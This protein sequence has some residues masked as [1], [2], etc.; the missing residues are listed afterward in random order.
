[1]KKFFLF[2]FILSFY[3]LST[4]S[5]YFPPNNSNQW[6]TLAPQRLG[7]CDYKIDSLYNF[8]ESSN[9]RGFIL[10]KDGKIV[11]EKY[12]NGHDLSKVWYWASAGKS[13][14]A[15]MV[16]IAQQD[17]LLNINDTS[18][19]Y[20]GKG[21]TS[22]PQAKEDLITIYHQLSMSSGL[23]D[24]VA[25]EYCTIDTCLQYLSDAGTRW[26]YHNGP[27][28]LLDSVLNI[29]TK[30]KLNQYISQKLSGI[31]GIQGVFIK[32]GFNNVFYSTGRNMA[33]FGLLNLNKGN[34]NGT[35]ILKDKTYFEKMTTSSQALN[36]SYGYLWWLNGKSSYK[37]PGLQI[38]FPGSLIPNAP[39]D[40]Y[41]AMGKN[42]QFICVI[43][44]QNMVWVRF[45][46]NPD[47]SLVPFL[48]NGEIWKYINDLTCNTSNSLNPTPSKIEIKNTRSSIIINAVD[49]IVSCEVYDISG[50]CVFVSRPNLLHFDIENENWSGLYLL[51]IVAENGYKKVFKII[52]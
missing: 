48:L 17:G 51:Q 16:G 26:A 31:T 36:P 15:F 43:P 52:K 4:Q 10:L 37:V 21:W 6:D 11:L 42:G 45:G 40:L 3:K 47:N 24:N 44:S 7:W 50:K 39:K 8:L 46:D 2:I 30:I 49:K 22:C 38:S 1:M 9:S 25:D 18:S 12:F 34:W 29:A 33:R 5:L 14:T 27:Y 32:S 28:T 23:D 19:K 41:A 35:D 20:L 13:L